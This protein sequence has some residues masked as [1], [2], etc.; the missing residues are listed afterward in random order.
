[1][2]YQLVASAETHPLLAAYEIE[3]HPHLYQIF[4]FE[5]KEGDK[6]P[7]TEK[8][9][10]ERTIRA[11]RTCCGMTDEEVQKVLDVLAGV[12]FLTNTNFS[13]DSN[14]KASIESEYTLEKASQ[15]LKIDKKVL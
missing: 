11:L 5:F 10:F 15:I 13:E 3:S 12:L 2:F 14:E 6:L 8:D 4:G 7:D 1:V 9:E